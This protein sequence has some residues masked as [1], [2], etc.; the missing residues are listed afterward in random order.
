MIVFAIVKGVQITQTTETTQITSGLN[1][2]HLWADFYSHMLPSLRTTYLEGFHHS[3]AHSSRE[4]ST[5]TKSNIIVI[6]TSIHSF[7]IMIDTTK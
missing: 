3:G 6:I 7:K 4:V 5:E 2:M 1:P